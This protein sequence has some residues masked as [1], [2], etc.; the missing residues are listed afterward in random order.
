[1]CLGCRSPGQ[2]NILA[3]NPV[4]KW[5]AWQTASVW[6]IADQSADCS[7]TVHQR[8]S[9][10]FAFGRDRALRLL[11]IERVCYW[12]ARNCL[13]LNEDKIQIIWLDTRQQL[14]KNSK[15]L[16]QTLTVRN[17]MVLQLSLSTTVSNLGFLIA[18][19][20]TMAEH[21]A[22]VYCS[23]FF[24]LR[25]LRCIK[26]SLTPAATKKL[27]HAF[28]NSRL[29]YRNQLF[30]GVSASVAGCWTS[31]SHSRMLLL[32]CR[33][34]EPESLIALHLWVMRQLHWVPVRQRLKF[35]TAFLVFKCPRG[36]APVYLVD[37]CK[38]T[39]QHW[40][41]TFE[42]GQSVSVSFLFYGDRSITAC[43]P[44]T[45]NSLSSG[46]PALDTD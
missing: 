37:Y 23:G 43:G 15:N 29:D 5:M 6:V 31:C 2:P 34:R 26:Q 10:R 41:F 35:K 18:S 36:S 14:N 45:W 27:I 30:V 22:A 7:A 42:I 39:C 32:A 12:M 25:Q 4:R 9:W 33:W 17:G 13:K 16:P 40:S 8:A 24:Q 46:T 21:I 20:L 28:T 44:S 11:H 1:M 19:Q 3:R 38:S